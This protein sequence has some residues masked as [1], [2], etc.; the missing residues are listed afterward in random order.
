MN[1]I[2]ELAQP[3]REP[4]VDY[5]LG[6]LRVRAESKRGRVKPCYHAQFV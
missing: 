3:M 1:E 2:N 4:Q 6:R 5:E